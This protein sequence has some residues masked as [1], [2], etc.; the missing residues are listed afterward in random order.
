MA[1]RK[2]GEAKHTPGPWAVE[3]A[4]EAGEY[5]RRYVVT[6]VARAEGRE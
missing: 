1:E 6:A 2:Q 4:G 5:H 3:A